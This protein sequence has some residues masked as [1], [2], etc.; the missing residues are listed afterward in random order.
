MLQSKI[1]KQKNAVEKYFCKPFDKA[2]RVPIS[3]ENTEILMQLL[4]AKGALKIP[5]KEKPFLVKVIEGRLKTSFSFSIRDSRLTLFIAIISQTPG[6]AIMY[7]TYLQYW[8]KKNE[9]EEIDLE[10]FC[11]IFPMGFL[12]KKDLEKIWDGQKVQSKDFSISDNLL[13]YQSAMLSI[14]FLQPKQTQS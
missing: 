12:S 3:K 8:C 7:L 9:T 5:E 6:T 13:D 1:T 4:M 2:Q 10:K 11:E 14:H